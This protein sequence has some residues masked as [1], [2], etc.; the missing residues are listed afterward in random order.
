MT[1]TFSGRQKDYDRKSNV[2]MEDIEKVRRYMI[3][4][5]CGWR[6]AHRR[7]D[8]ARVLGMEDRHLRNVCA[9]IPEIMASHD[10]G[11]YILPLVDKTGEE[12]K[13]ARSIIDG[14]DRRR[15]ISLYL[16]QRRR[17]KAI[18]EMRGRGGVQTDLFVVC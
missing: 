1:N 17:R 10:L 2:S 18:E 9:E 6:R 15:L 14:E 13:V 7:Q 3:D 16:R 5:H 8:I 11:Y 4:Y 12:T